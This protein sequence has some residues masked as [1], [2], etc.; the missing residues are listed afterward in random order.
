[1]RWPAD[2][3][4]LL[5][6]V[7][8]G[9]FL[10]DPKMVKEQNAWKERRRQNQQQASAFGFSPNSPSGEAEKGPRLFQATRRMP[11]PA[12][13]AA[14]DLDEAWLPPFKESGE[15]YRAIRLKW[16]H[17]VLRYHPD[18]QQS[19]LSPEQQATNTSEYMKAM[20]AFEAIDT[21]Y[22]LHFAPKDVAGWG[23]TPAAA[24]SPRE[25]TGADGAPA[26]TAAEPTA[27]AAEPTAPAKPA[28]D[29]SDGTAAAPELP[30]AAAGDAAAGDAA[31]SDASAAKQ[32]ANAA[33]ATARAARPLLLKQRVQIVGLQAKAAY[34]GRTGVA[35]LFDRP[36]GRYAVE[37][38]RVS[39]DEAAERLKVREANLCLVEGELV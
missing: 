20:A 36:A 7:M 28:V 29:V 16:R 15:H 17:A 4:E 9:F 8:R 21:H 5:Y 38:D 27:A 26:P 3:S 31:A 22:A 39:E 18:R 37:L 6:D 12:A 30:K 13:F 11:L 19:S 34:N 33:A 24:T 32:S 1:V 10:P 14:L 25:P 23:E 35:I 2:T